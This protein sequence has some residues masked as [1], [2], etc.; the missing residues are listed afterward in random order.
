MYSGYRWVDEGVVGVGFGVRGVLGGWVLVLGGWVLGYLKIG[1][2]Y[3]D[4]LIYL[5]TVR[6]LLGREGEVESGGR[7]G[8]ER[9]GVLVLETNE[10]RWS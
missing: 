5:S 2:S 9:R 7:G 8:E 1:L 6:V 10:Y 3:L 4:F